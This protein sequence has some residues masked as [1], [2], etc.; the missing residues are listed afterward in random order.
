M[1]MILGAIAAVALATPAWAGC[2]PECPDVGLTI[3][4]LLDIDRG[5][6]TEQ[7]EVTLFKE[8]RVEDLGGTS[9][10]L[11]LGLATPFF[12]G[13]PLL[14]KVSAAITLNWTPSAEWTPLRLDLR[15]PLLPV[16]D[17]RRDRLIDPDLIEYRIYLPISRRFDFNVSP[18]WGNR[19]GGVAME[20]GFWFAPRDPVP[21]GFAGPFVFDDAV[22][23]YKI[24]YVPEPQIWALWIVGLGLAGAVLR[25]RK[26]LSA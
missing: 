18:V 25:Q 8:F 19:G 16:D 21:V 1:K 13:D 3:T 10:S 12:I 6:V 2:P 20:A 17:Y 5:G 7:R 14:D 4:T 9:G 22:F 26:P 24:S 11:R 15:Y 23:E